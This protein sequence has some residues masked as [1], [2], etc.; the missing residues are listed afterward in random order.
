MFKSK[1]AL[2]AGTAALTFSAIFFVTSCHKKD[3]TTTTSEDTGYTTD[4]ATAEKSFTDVQS[5]SDQASTV[6]SGGSLGY[7]T[8]ELTS[9]CAT[10]TRTP[11]GTSGTMT[12]DFGSS[13]CLCLDGRYRRGQI[14]V[15]YT[16]NYADSGSVHTITFNNY[17]QNDN[18]VQGTKTV[19][20][21]GH[22][23]LGQPYFSVV[24][25]GS[26]T[27]STGGVVSAAWTRTRT[28]TAGYNTP[29][30]FSD[31]QYAITGSGTITRANGTVVTVAISNS[32][33]LIIASGCRWIEAGSLTYTLPSGLTRT[34]NYGSTPACDD[35]AVLTLPSGATY[36]ITLP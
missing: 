7:K 29:G 10:V 34:I 15:N 3:T 4:Q 2:L 13:N 24:V 18:Q 16:G 33:P 22:N 21:M 14:I 9:G 25:A 6:A 23:A 11:T 1:I 36:T 31:D 20:N 35:Q 30:V 28:W 32:A 12:I 8:A 26:I 17:F 19:T 27:K 5:I